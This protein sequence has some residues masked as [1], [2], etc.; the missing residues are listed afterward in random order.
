[1]HMGAG[2]KRAA[3]RTP[4][5]G[6]AT[7][8]SP[9]DG[10]L[11]TGEVWSLGRGGLRLK[12][13]HNIGVISHRPSD[14]AHFRHRSPRLLRPNPLTVARK[15]RAVTEPRV[16]SA[17]C[18]WALERRGQ[19]NA[20]LLRDG[21]LRGAGLLS[22]WHRGSLEFGAERAPPQ[23]S[24]QH[25]GDIAPPLDSAHFRHRSPRLLRPDPLTVARKGR[26]VTEPRAGTGPCTWA[27]ERRGQR[28]HTCREMDN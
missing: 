11:R 2:A 27:L 15:G 13:P 4:A 16:G 26:A 7:E 9:P 14:S 18:T 5:M 1:M 25:R 22:K 17:P 3:Q 21:Q 6:W 20:H 23:E 10:L 28:S 19:R 12:S 24:A 8:G